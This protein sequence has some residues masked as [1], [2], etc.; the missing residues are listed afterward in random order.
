MNDNLDGGPAFPFN[1]DSTLHMGM[2]LRD[3]IATHA[4]QGLIA[5]SF[6]H[7]VVCSADAP[8]WAENAYAFADAMLKARLG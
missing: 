4:L 5:G 8:Q 2:S 7:R 1:P 6:Q 3:F